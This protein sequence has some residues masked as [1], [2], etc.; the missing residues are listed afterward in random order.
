MQK[1]L[2]A[3]GRDY[4]EEYFE[5]VK[6]EGLTEHGFPRLTVN[7]GNL[8]CKGK[9]LELKP[10]F[11]KMMDF[12]CETVP[13]VKA[14]ND[15]S[16]WEMV[17]CITELEKSG[18]VDKERI[19]VWKKNMSSIDPAICYNVYA[20]NPEDK[21]KNWA[22]FTGVSEFFRLSAGLGGSMDFIDTQLATQLQ[23]IDENGMYLDGDEYWNPLV[24]DVVPRGLFSLLLNHGYRGKYYKEI[25]DIL[26]RA[27]LLTLK[28]QS[29]CGEL[30]FGGRSNQFIF[31]E[32]WLALVCEFEA[33]R[34]FKEGNFRL[35]NE[36]KSA[37]KRAIE[38]VEFWLNKQP[39]HHVKNRYPLETRHGCEDYA[40]FDKYMITV[41]SV[42]QALL[43]VCD[44]NIEFEYITDCEPMVFATTDYFHKLFLKA[45][46][47]SAQFDINAEPY[48]DSNGLG[49]I[50]KT[51]APTT[52]CMS[53]PCSSQDGYVTMCIEKPNAVSLCVG[54]IIDGKMVFAHDDN[55]SYE[56]LDYH[57]GEAF[58]YAKI[59]NQFK[60]GLT[61]TTE[62]KVDKNGVEIDVFG[63]GELLFMLPA[64]YF[65]GERYFKVVQEK[66]MLSVYQD[67]WVCNYVA[68]GEVFDLER[69]GANRNGLYKAFAVKGKDK[70]IIKVQIVKE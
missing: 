1:A 31:T 55:A 25:D 37:S 20:V 61:I 60:N 32:V 57:T 14:A 29:A 22:L 58:A 3:Y 13:K 18:K 47:Y 45:G 16:V 70:I 42:L 9:V 50:H 51:G 4:I 56:I 38:Q 24:Y 53:V 35:V 23:W 49:R 2:S 33:K 68:D 19:D 17:Y 30:A 10:L 48:I 11:L 27:G 63:K 54:A 15:F 28:M 52:V 34:Y 5:R 43:L 12:C 64:F 62:Y 67:G 40:Y 46:G 44:E 8:I 39:I 59:K 65:D 69:R 41:A 6:T 26:K 21:L 36:F 66:N 7:I